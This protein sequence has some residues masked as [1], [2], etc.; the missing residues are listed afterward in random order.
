MFLHFFCHTRIL[1]FLLR[2]LCLFRTILLFVSFNLDY[3]VPHSKKWTKLYKR[4]KNFIKIYNR[5]VNFIYELSSFTL[6][7]FLSSP[8]FFSSRLPTLFFLFQG[9]V[10]SLV[11]HIFSVKPRDWSLHVYVCLCMCDRV[12]MST[13]SMLNWLCFEF[14]YVDFDFVT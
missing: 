4:V 8:D 7:F 12:Y 10:Q 13:M 1:K 14:L 9:Y 2:I 3:L 11:F 5:Y 6:R